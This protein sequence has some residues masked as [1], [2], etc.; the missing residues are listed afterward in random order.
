MNINSVYVSPGPVEGLKYDPKAHGIGIVHFGVGAFHR[1]HQAVFTHDALTKCGGDWRILGVSLRSSKTADALNLQDGLYSLVTRPDDRSD[2]SIRLIASIAKVEAAARCKDFLFETLAS[3]KTSIVS[4][5]VTEKA[6]GILRQSASVDIS[7]EAISRDLKEPDDPA[8]V[9]G[10]IVKGLSLRKRA[11]VE[12]F[13][14]LCC[15]NLP[16]NGDLVRSGVVDFARRIDPALADWIAEHGA[17]PSS[18]VDRITPAVTPELIEEVSRI[19]GVDDHAAIEA[20][21]FSQWV[22]EDNFVGA[23]PCWEKAGAIFVPDVSPYEQMKLRMLNG[24]HSLVAYAGFLT[25]KKY[26]R[27]AMLDD[28]IAKLVARH[29]NAASLTL[30]PLTGVEFAEYAEDLARRFRNPN[31]AHETYQIAMDG[32]RKLPQRIFE[33]ALESLNRGVSI[34]PFAFATALWMRYCVGKT[35]DGALY[36]LRD[37]RENQLKAIFDRHESSVE[38][39]REQIFA[40]PD[41]MPAARQTR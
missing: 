13:T 6:Y 24:P 34:D 7:H 38:H 22:I 27:D 5:T 41:F 37:P 31:I 28:A 33:P 15:D 20:E 35:E 25:G 3:P 9:I 23:R 10:M 21:P 17:F 8:G 11:G 30:E 39:I 2:A 32:T 16:K 4:M 29:I 19:L 18:M 12:P 26:V 14:V 40:M 1:A 36:D